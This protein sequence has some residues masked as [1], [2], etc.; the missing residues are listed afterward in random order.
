VTTVKPPMIATTA[1]I[2]QSHIDKLLGK[3]ET[4][5]FSTDAII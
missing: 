5:G 1:T 3:D 4:K 2:L